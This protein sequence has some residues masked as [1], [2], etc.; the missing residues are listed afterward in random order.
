MNLSYQNFDIK[1]RE[2]QIDPMMLAR[3]SVQLEILR[4]LSHSP[5][6]RI[7]CFKGGTALHLIF[8]MDRYS[9]DLDFSLTGNASPREIRA[10]LEDILEGEEVTD[11]EVKRSTVVM[12]VRQKFQPQ[13]FRVKLEVNTDNIVPAELKTLHSEYLPEA[14]A[15]QTMR[16]DHLVGQ[17][18]RALLQRKKGRDLYDLWFILKTK[19]PLSIPL[20]SKLTDIPQ[21]E[22]M[23]RVRHAIS[24]FD[25]KKLA[26]DLN[27]FVRRP[28]RDWVRKGLKEDVLRLLSLVTTD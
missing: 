25:G 16:L 10:A 11:R 27:P 24:S 4:R 19:L 1:A 12:E 26:L 3:E 2:R 7:L 14:F 22:I 8:S 28:L 21:G 18:I 5:L 9:E 20:I 15:L 13:N 23:D 6:K 17:K